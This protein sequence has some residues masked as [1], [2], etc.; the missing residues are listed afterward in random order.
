MIKVAIAGIYF[1]VTA[2][3]EYFVRAFKRRTDCE[4]KTIGPYNGLHIPW[5]KNGTIGMIMPDRYDFAPDIILPYTGFMKNTP[6]G[7]VEGLLEDF[8]PDLWLDV[9]AGFYLDGRPKSGVKTAFLTDP[10][11]LRNWYNSIKKIYDVIFCPQTPYAST[12]EIYLP[13]AADVEWH[14]RIPNLDQLYDISLI[15]NT[16]PN[17]VE[18]M[19]QLRNAGHK[20]YFELGVAKEDARKVYSQSYIGVNWSS[21]QDLTARVF[22]IS[23]LGVVPVVNQVPDLNGL[24]QENVHYLSFSDISSARTQINNV[25]ND[26]ALGQTIANNAVKN[27][28]E[29]KHTWDDRVS[30]ILETAHLL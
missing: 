30:T 14:S 26:R 21:L 9:N 6:I 25:L 3:L 24:F 8:K 15:G 20:T 13:Y 29:N 17:R 4:V 16:Y 12:G 27:I 19:N 5:S 10:H 7:Y 11:V 28:I 18:L 2:A 1:P 23:L 22:E